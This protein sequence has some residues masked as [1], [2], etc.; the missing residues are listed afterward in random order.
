M[1]TTSIRI[2]DETMKIVEKTCK[3]LEIESKTNVI[4]ILVREGAKAR[5]VKI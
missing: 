5:G 2:P 3:H 4:K 1:N